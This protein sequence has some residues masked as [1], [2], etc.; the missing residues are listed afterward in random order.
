[1]GSVHVH[2]EGHDAI[3]TSGVRRRWRWKDLR[4]LSWRG[5]QGQVLLPSMTG[6]PPP[7]PPPRC[8]EISHPVS[9]SQRTCWIGCVELPLSACMPHWMC[10]NHCGC[11]HVHWVGTVPDGQWARGRGRRGSFLRGPKPPPPSS[12]KPKVGFGHGSDERSPRHDRPC[13]PGHGTELCA[14]QVEGR[15]WG[16]RG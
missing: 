4:P 9:V 7:P 3:S 5:W 12:T 11:F 1:M 16:E 6:P 14:P 2:E 10:W 15:V 13:P 8:A